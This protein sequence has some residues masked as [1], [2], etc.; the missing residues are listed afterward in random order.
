MVL[1]QCSYW[2]ELF[3]TDWS[4]SNIRLHDNSRNSNDLNHCFKS[5]IHGYFGRKQCYRVEGLKNNAVPFRKKEI[6]GLKPIIFILNVYPP[7]LFQAG[8]PKM[9]GFT[10]VCPS[11]SFHLL[12]SV[13]YS[14]LPWFL[15]PS[16]PICLSHKPLP[17]L[18]FP[19]L[20]SLFVLKVSPIL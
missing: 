12:F 3:P 16:S 13:P 9:C 10:L 18:H 2:K 5:Y 20:P 4:I 7:L 1:G 8:Q 19:F 15:V 17:H 6:I 11:L 14:D